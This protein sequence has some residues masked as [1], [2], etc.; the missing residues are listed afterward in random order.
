MLRDEIYC[1]GG[2]VTIKGI[3]V[4]GWIQLSSRY[5]EGIQLET[6]STCRW[7]FVF[8][9]NTGMTGP[10][11]LVY[12]WEDSAGANLTAAV[13]LKAKSQ[14]KVLVLPAGSGL[15]RIR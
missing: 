10:A 11:N 15:W 14:T 1:K 2:K 3:V 9:Q 7:V 5:R 8:H 6:Y 12:P 4:D 13:C